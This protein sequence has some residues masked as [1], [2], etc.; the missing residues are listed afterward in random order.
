MTKKS[1]EQKQYELI[2]K[3]LYRI[4]ATAKQVYTRKIQS[5]RLVE[6]F[7]Y[8]RD[9]MQ[10]HM[11][12]HEVPALEVT[13]AVDDLAK[14]LE[15]QDDIE[16]LERIYGPNVMDDVGRS[17]QVLQKARDDEFVRRNNPALQKAWDNYQLL[18]KIAGG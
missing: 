9:F 16:Q 6:D 11:H 5:P 4:G 10:Y 2:Q 18:L 13:I 17:R 1:N 8:H 15:R 3:Y 14:L 12:V 7:D